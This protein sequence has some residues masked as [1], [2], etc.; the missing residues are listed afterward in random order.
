[1][2]EFVVKGRQVLRS[3]DWL[4]DIWD[5]HC[6]IGRSHFSCPRKHRGGGSHSQIVED[7]SGDALDPLYTQ[8][9]L[10]ARTPKAD[11]DVCQRHA[12][13]SLVIP[14]L[15]YRHD[16]LVNDFC[17]IDASHFR[18]CLRREFGMT[19]KVAKIHLLPSCSPTKT[20]LAGDSWGQIA[21]P[22]M[23][24]QPLTIIIFVGALV[25]IVYGIMNLIVAATL[26]HL[27]NSLYINL[28]RCLAWRVFFSG[29]CGC[30]SRAGREGYNHFGR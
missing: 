20:M 28:I 19:A 10:F 12:D 8:G 3:L 26:L 27:L 23:K 25:S 21:V 24:K 22:V 29:N 30:C 4:L 13:V 6:V 11:D 16:P 18:S 1:M 9:T 14:L 2:A 15:L 17:R 5:H 7:L